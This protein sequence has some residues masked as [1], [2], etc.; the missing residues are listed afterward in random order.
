M[1]M[2]LLIY[3][4]A[5]KFASTVSEAGANPVTGGEFH[6]SASLFVVVHP[7]IR[8][9]EPTKRR[10]KWNTTIQKLLSF[11]TIQSP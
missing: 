11:Q 1:F 8:P 6:K 7:Y 5:Y 10:W 3:C 2:Y 4:S 9:T